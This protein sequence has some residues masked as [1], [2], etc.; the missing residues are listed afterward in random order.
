VQTWDCHGRANQHWSLSQVAAVEPPPPPAPPP[1]PPPVAGY[2][3]G[4]GHLRNGAQGLCLDVHGWAARGDSITTLGE[5]NNDPDQVWSFSPTGE[6]VNAVGQRCLDVAGYNGAQ[7]DAIDIYA[8]EAMDDQR[9][10]LVPRGGGSFELHSRKRNL[11]LDV[12]GQDGGRGEKMMLW[13][14]DG[15]RDQVWRWEPIGHPHEVVYEQPVPPPP[16]PPAEIRPMHHER[17][18]E[19]I[20]AVNNQG[21][22]Q[23]KLGVIQQ[24]AATNYFRVAQLRELVLA[25]SFSGDR[26][27]AVEL[28]APRIVDRENAFTL[29]DA[30]SFSSEKER[31]R[32]ILEAAP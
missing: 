23:G 13:A 19:L 9:W 28:V 18:Q 21:F 30:F 11:C 7:G 16:P 31:A 14:C 20:A 12:A 10:N 32:K 24:A 29:Y 4:T 6:L 22:S 26:I 1:P 2:P 8:C 3:R 27:R 25:L 15:G 17:F 5:C